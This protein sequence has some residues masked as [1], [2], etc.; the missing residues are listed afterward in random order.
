MLKIKRKEIV[1]VYIRQNLFS[2]KIQANIGVL[3]VSNAPIFAKTYNTK[4]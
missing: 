1:F 2:D 3:M 4:L